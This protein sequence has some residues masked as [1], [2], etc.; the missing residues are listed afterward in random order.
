LGATTIVSTSGVTGVKGS[1][2]GVSDLISTAG[3]GSSGVG[4]KEGCWYTQALRVQ[5]KVSANM[6][7]TI[8]GCLPHITK[9]L[10]YHF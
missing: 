7:L 6:P 3:G 4:L 1:E 2:T 9:T 8:L 10:P 5:I